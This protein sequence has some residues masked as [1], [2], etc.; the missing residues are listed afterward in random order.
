MTRRLDAIRFDA[1]NLGT[2]GQDANVKG[3]Q[4][5]TVDRRRLNGVELRPNRAGKADGSDR[6]DPA[7]KPAPE[8]FETDA[9][10]SLDE[11]LIE[12]VMPKVA[13]PAILRRSVSILRYCIADLVP[14]LDGGD[15][16]RD[17]AQSLMEEEIE[18]HRDLWE[19][20]QKEAEV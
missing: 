10:R 7:G 18:R 11:D 5:R 4:G 6:T 14:G 13:G 1:S 3:L 17:L 2:S 15:Q 8:A 19:R 20:L 12:F 9:G 16:L